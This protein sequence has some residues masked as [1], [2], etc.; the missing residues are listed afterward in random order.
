MK[1]GGTYYRPR[2]LA[3]GH[4]SAAGRRRNRCW[5]FRRLFG[6]CPSPVPTNQ[7][8]MEV[9]AGRDHMA[10]VV[11][12]FIFDVLVS[13]FNVL[14]PNVTI[15]AVDRDVVAEEELKPSLRHGDRIDF[16]CRRNCPVL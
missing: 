11:E 16:A 2:D 8:E 10:V 3:N 12:A 9:E 6:P 7:L 15:G 14:Q 5:L 1:I 4:R 13:R